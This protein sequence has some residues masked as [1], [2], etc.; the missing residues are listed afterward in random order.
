[1]KGQINSAQSLRVA[2]LC[3]IV[4]VDFSHCFIL[5]LMLKYLK[6]EQYCKSVLIIEIENLGQR[7][8]L[9]S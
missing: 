1:M 6:M 7:S 3:C 4:L 9:F 5:Y 8:V 2:T